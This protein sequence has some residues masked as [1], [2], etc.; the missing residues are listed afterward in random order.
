MVYIETHATQYVAQVSLRQHSQTWGIHLT[1]AAML[2]LQ[3]RDPDDE[4]LLVLDKSNVKVATLIPL[5]VLIRVCAAPRLIPLIPF[6][7]LHCGVTL[8]MTVLDDGS[9]SSVPCEELLLDS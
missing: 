7:L 6:L 9:K 2:S 4:G 1:Q 5:R 3:P 8:I